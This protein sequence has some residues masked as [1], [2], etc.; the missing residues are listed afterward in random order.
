MRFL[1]EIENLKF[2]YQLGFQKVEALRGVSLKI[3]HSSFVGLCGPSGSG[4]TTLL[5]LLGL[6]ENIQDGSILYNGKSIR[7]LSE[8]NKNELRKYD[9][10]FVF[11][12][13][14]LSPVLRAEENVEYFLFRQ[15]VPVKERRDR[16][17]LALEQVGLWEHR[18]KKPLEM[19]GGQR[20]RV[21][22]A[23]A[24]AKNPKVIIADEPTA[25]LDQKTGREIMEIF[26]KLCRYHDVSILLSTHD[27]MA[28]SYA[29][30]IFDLSDGEILGER[31]KEIVHDSPDFL[32]SFFEVVGG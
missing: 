29:D 10:G 4:K 22:I 8:E 27:P 24:L 28:Q 20:Q 32:D 7:E 26:K 11:Q 16:V 1:Y 5:S 30:H 17:R 25:S 21:A 23:R 18:K 6:I 14:N 31:K 19:S 3:P 2:S 15:G 9:L 13:F 12:T